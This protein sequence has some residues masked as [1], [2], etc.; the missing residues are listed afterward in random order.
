MANEGDRKL[1]EA[2]WGGCGWCPREWASSFGCSVSFKQRVTKV[3]E[4][5]VCEMKQSGWSNQK[6]D[7]KER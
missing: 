6:R 7:C 1:C 2:E 3:D 4:N 5:N